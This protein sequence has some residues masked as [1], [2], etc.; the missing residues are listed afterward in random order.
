MGGCGRLPLG[1]GSGNSH[2]TG[3]KG[4]TG[5]RDGAWWPW[6]PC[7]L[8]VLWGASR[9]VTTQ[10]GPAQR[11]AFCLVSQNLVFLTRRGQRI[12]ALWTLMLSVLVLEEN[13]A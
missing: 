11:R 2:V 8:L 13:R 1:E 9:C 4:R 5:P 7:V 10:V 3:V 12:E 6:E